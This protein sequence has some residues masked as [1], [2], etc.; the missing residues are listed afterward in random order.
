VSSGKA[1]MYVCDEP[2]AVLVVH[3]DRESWTGDVVVHVW[4][5]HCV[6]ALDQMQDETYALLDE[7]KAKAGATRIVMDGRVG[8]QKRG[9]K[10]RKIIYER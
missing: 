3:L 4:L 9:W 1:A 7:L 6:G 10:I 2:E 5:C 8:W